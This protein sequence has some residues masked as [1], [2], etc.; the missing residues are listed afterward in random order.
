MR[1]M[2]LLWANFSIIHGL[3]AILEK[4]QKRVFDRK[5]FIKITLMAA[6]VYI[7]MFDSDLPQV[8]TYPIIEICLMIVAS[9]Y[10]YCEFLRLDWEEW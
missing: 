8:G 3:I 5:A 6:V 9:L 4:A 7:V 1:S 2:F 10:S